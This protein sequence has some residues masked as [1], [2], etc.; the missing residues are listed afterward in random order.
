MR[1]CIWK[2]SGFWRCYL[3][4]DIIYS[5]HRDKTEGNFRRDIHSGFTL[6]RRS[7]AFSVGIRLR[8]FLFSTSGLDRRTSYFHR[9]DKMTKLPSRRRS[10]LGSTT[11]VSTAPN[12]AR[13]IAFPDARASPL[14]SAQKNRV[15]SGS[16]RRSKSRRRQISRR[17]AVGRECEGVRVSVGGSRGGS[18]RFGEIHVDQ[19]GKEAT[20]RMCRTLNHRGNFS[21]DNWLAA[22]EPHDW[23]TRFTTARENDTLARHFRGR[24]ALFLCVYIDHHRRK[25]PRPNEEKMGD[26]SL[27]LWHFPEWWFNHQ[28][29]G[30][31]ESRTCALLPWCT[32]NIESWSST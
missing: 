29:L 32:R 1:D 20:V 14:R 25:A 7:S 26:A 27:T 23:L 13:V 12:R 11:G 24:P 9:R 31:N 4:S 21:V 19:P 15:E 28:S 10:R 16:R 2:S 30:G 17:R 5:R 6:I 3:I 18:P 8:N 22:L